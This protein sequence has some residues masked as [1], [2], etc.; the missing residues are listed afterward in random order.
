M[1][2][3]RIQ[4]LIGHEIARMTPLSGGMIAEVYR[5]DFIDGQSVAVKVA[6]GDKAILDVEGR[7]LRYL[8]KHSELPIPEVIHSESNLL[9]M[10]YI[11]NQGGISSNVQEDAAHHLASLHDIS[12]E[13]FG[14]NFDT[15]I[16]SLHQPNT[17]YDSWIDFFREQRLI[18]MADI[19]Y[20]AQQLPLSI[21]QRIEQFAPQ[22]DDLLYEPDVPSLIHGDMWS[23]NILPKNDHIAGFIDPAIY[24]AHPE[25]ELAFS[26]LFGTFGQAFFDTYHNLRPIEPDF[27]EERRYIYNLFPL[28]VHVTLF[29]TGYVSQVDTILKKFSY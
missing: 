11:D 24:Y 26:T 25:I 20:K 2:T 1:N 22:L 5:V 15:L 27:F 16:G 23:G 12:S 28:L 7:M 19:A 8:A 17:Q 4:N 21:R 9:I 3:D 18:Y 6:K 10:R 14:L 13:K 29:G